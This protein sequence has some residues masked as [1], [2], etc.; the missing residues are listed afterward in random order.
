M[1]VHAL[2]DLETLFTPEDLPPGTLGEITH[3]GLVLFDLDAGRLI[4]SAEW[5]PAPGNGAVCED[6]VRWWM[7]QCRDGKFPRWVTVREERKTKAML[8]CLMDLQAFIPPKAEVWGNAPNMDL[9][10][11]EDHMAFH[12]LTRPWGAFQQNDVRSIRKWLGHRADKAVAHDALQDALNEA[13]RLIAWKKG[14]EAVT[15]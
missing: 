4:D 2:I 11:L 5:F 3:I 6:T 15:A 12:R 1:S 14:M 7:K 10:P 8:S 9:A 13:G